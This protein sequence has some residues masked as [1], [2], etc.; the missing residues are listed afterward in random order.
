MRCG[1]PRACSTS[2]GREHSRARSC[3]QAAFVLR[4]TH[5]QPEEERLLI[6][7]LGRDLTVPAFPEPL[8]APPEDCEWATAWSSEDPLYGAAGAPEA[9]GPHGWQILGLSATVLKPVEATDERHRE[10]V[11]N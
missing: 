8:V 1:A 3:P 9:C 10:R 4:F 7:N 2:S 5:E 6:L 11:G